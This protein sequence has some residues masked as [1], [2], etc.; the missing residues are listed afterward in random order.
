MRPAQRFVLPLAAALI[1]VAPPALAQVELPRES[2][3][4]RVSQLA[5]LTEIAIDYASPAAGGRR[6]WGGVVPYGRLWQ[7]GGH[8]APRVRFSRDVTI[9]GKPVPA[10]AYDLSAIPDRAQW[11]VILSRESG[12]EAAR[13]V[14]RPHAG[15]LHDRLTFSFPSFSEDQ[16]IVELAWERVSVELLIGLD[17]S[18]QVGAT[19]AGLDS[20]WRTYANVARYM[21]ETKRDYEAGLHYVDQSLA[22]REDWFNVWI[23]ALLLAAKRDFKGA[24]SEAERAYG[25]GVK[26]GDPIFPAPEIKK[27]AADWSAKDVAAR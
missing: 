14:V 23:R 27:A 18:R 7:G 1:G 4:G 19:L 2:P 25:L 21:L 11:T 17:T 8:Q 3:P 13:L 26:S 24:A 6:I 15:P 22:L 10:G 9:G 20:T 12:G 16:A 5:G